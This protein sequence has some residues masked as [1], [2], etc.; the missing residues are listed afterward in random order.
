MP[1]FG[2]FGLEFSKNYCHI[3]SHH[4]QIGPLAK[5]C[6]KIIM[7]KFGTK[8]ALFGHFWASIFK[9]YCHILNQYP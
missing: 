7:S 6:E 5:F 3:G 8:T 4:P 9:R 1:Y 2:I